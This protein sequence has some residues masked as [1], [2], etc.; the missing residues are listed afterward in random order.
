VVD[1]DDLRVTGPPGAD[2]LVG[3]VR[4]E[5]ARIADGG[6]NDTG[7]LPEVLLVAPE[8]AKAEDGRPGPV[9]ERRDDP[10]AVDEVGVRDFERL[11]SARQGVGGGGHGRTA[12]EE[13]HGLSVITNRCDASTGWL[14]RL[15]L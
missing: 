15:H 5:S 8:A 9:G 2:L 6:R 11:G 7:R 13:E 10:G 14:D 1:Q 4:R 12:L 3:R